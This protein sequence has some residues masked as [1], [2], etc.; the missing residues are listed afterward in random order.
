MDAAKIEQ[1]T[2]G[3]YYLKGEKKPFTGSTIKHHKNGAKMEEETYKDGKLHGIDRG[4]HANGKKTY[5]SAWM[6][7][8]E[9]GLL[10]EW[11]ER[12]NKINVWSYAVSG[13]V[14]CK[15]T[16]ELMLS[17]IRL[18]EKNLGVDHQD[19]AFSYSNIAWIYSDKGED[20]KALEFYRK[21][22]AIELKQLGPDHVDVGDSY[23]FIGQAYYQIGEYDKALEHHHKSLA[24][25]LKKQPDH[26]SVTTGYNNIGRNLKIA[27]APLG[28]R[29]S[30]QAR[31]S[32]VSKAN[33]SPKTFLHFFR[34]TLSRVSGLYPTRPIRPTNQ[35]P[36]KQKEHKMKKLLTI[37]AVCL[38][39]GTASAQSVYVSSYFKS[40][41]SYVQG[42][43]R[44]KADGNFHNN[45][46]ITAGVA[47]RSFAGYTTTSGGGTAVKLPDA[48]CL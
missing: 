44:S 25:Y 20:N 31:S 13:E 24:I 10:T 19:V 41:G 40:N 39:I 3:L 22:L 15:K 48:H 18:N 35:Q 17:L 5:E 33:L 45:W 27:R 43:H 16:V 23:F 28:W 36:K 1:R 38:T 30:W 9:I 37:I 7:G 46:F 8:I 21:T 12:G 29:F 6:Q 32:S 34:K 11:S 42:H 47:K 26:P 2:D 4:W 14:D